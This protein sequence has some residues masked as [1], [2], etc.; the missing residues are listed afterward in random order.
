MTLTKYFLSSLVKVG[1]CIKTVCENVMKIPE[2]T[3]YNSAHILIR[4]PLRW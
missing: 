1:G 4:K 3:F 2:Q